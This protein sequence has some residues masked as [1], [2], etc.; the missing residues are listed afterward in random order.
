VVNPLKIYLGWDPREQDAY[1]VAEY[2]IRRR[3]SIPVSIFPLKLERLRD[4]GLMR[5]PMERRG[6]RLHDVISDRSQSTDFS[7]AR[8]LVPF[9]AHTG[10]AIFMDCDVVVFEDIAKLLALFD[11]EKAVQFVHHNYIN[12]PLVKMDDQEQKHYWGKNWSS[13]V[14]WNCDHPAHKRL[15]LDVVNGAHRDYLHQFQWIPR[16]Q[17]GELPASWNWLVNVFERPDPLS[18]AHFTEGGPWL[19][20][21]RR[22]DHDSL[23]LEERD[24]LVRPPMWHPV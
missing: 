8:F 15:T 12:G 19:G 7:I 14:L 1:E 13:V 22:A 3:S 23:W 10:P 6:N 21:W 9:L 2:S 18:L 20:G 24:R 5:R 11:T 16:D 4:Q 17:Q